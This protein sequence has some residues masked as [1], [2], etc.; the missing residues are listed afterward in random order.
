MSTRVLLLILF[1]AGAAI[2][3]AY[4]WLI[5]PLTFSESSPAQTMKPYR[6]A[7]LIM[8]AEAY[9]QDGDWERTQARVNALRDANLARTIVD[10]FD[11][12]QANGPNSTARALARLAARLNVRTPA[13]QVYLAAIVTPTPKA[14][15]TI[16]AAASQVVAVDGLIVTPGILDIHTHVFAG[17][18][19]AY[20]GENSVFPDS[21]S[22][23]TG[24]TT[25]VDAGE[26]I[27]IQTPTAGGYGKA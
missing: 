7:W 27:I 6:E 22:F 5:D 11:R 10:L 9:A 8:S 19:P 4:A 2:G 14:A 12:Y 3:L 17:D 21:H 24:V 13:M 16:G 25:V 18:G 20:T 26:A 1:V 23:R 15:A